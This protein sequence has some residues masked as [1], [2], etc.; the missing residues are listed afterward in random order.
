MLRSSLTLTQNL[1]AISHTCTQHIHTH[2]QKSHT[3]TELHC[4]FILT[5]NAIK[6]FL[7]TFDAKFKG[8][9][10]TIKVHIQEHLMLDCIRS[11]LAGCELIG[12]KGAESIH[13]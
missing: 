2:A 8:T 6:D 11:H 5:G 7:I 4:I 13:S 12:E 1:Q 9:R 3:N 10:R